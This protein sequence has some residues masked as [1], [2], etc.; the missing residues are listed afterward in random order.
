M[1]R[2]SNCMARMTKCSSGM[3]REIA[4]D[5]VGR[6]VGRA[7]RPQVPDSAGVDGVG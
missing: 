3:A 2:N 1:K 4:G 5:T 7:A 6:G